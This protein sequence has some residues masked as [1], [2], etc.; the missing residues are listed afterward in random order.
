MAKKWSMSV[1]TG[2]CDSG[3][4]VV[5][6]TAGMFSGRQW[7]MVFSSASSH[8]TTAVLRPS[9]MRLFSFSHWLT[10]RAWMFSVG[11]LT[12]FTCFASFIVSKMSVR[13]ASSSLGNFSFRRLMYLL[14]SLATPLWSCMKYSS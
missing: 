11:A 4:P 6:F 1:V 7:I 14:A 3:Y 13:E 10:Y 8:I 2:A 12:Y 5:T 9:A